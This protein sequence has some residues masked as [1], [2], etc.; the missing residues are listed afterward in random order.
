MW[1]LNGRGQL[2][3]KTGKE[4]D[5]APRQERRAAWWREHSRDWRHG[6]FG[7]QFKRQNGLE[8]LIDWILLVWVGGWE[9]RQKERR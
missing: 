8:S 5:V 2:K 4:S 1:R 3:T 6:R 7:R 9:V